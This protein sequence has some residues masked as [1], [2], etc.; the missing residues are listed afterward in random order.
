[1]SLNFVVNSS[2]L[3]PRPDTETLVETAISISQADNVKRI[4]DVGT[5][6]G[7]IAVSLAVYL[8]DT[9]II[10]VDI[11]PEALQVA[12]DNADRHE[13]HIQFRAGNLLEPISVDE[14]MDMIVANLPYIP[15]EEI[16][17]LEFGVKGY[18]PVLALAAP[19][20]GLDLYRRLLPQAYELL[21]AG[22][23]LLIEID[24]RQ[25]KAAL[26]M[27]QYFSESVIIPDWAGRNRVIKARKPVE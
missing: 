3:I 16:D 1:M 17:N 27:M 20:D 10:A 2:V 25:A 6:S 13:V 8:P 18:E 15:N 4:C 14:E 5:G 22:G 21:R 24:P 12:R 9:N 26:E 11:S 19:G 23:Y 7:A